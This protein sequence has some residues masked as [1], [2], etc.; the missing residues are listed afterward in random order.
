[1]RFKTA[2][3][4]IFLLLTMPIWVIPWISFLEDRKGMATM[5]FSGP[6]FM[7]V[8]CFLILLSM[9]FVCWLMCLLC[10]EGE[11]FKN[12]LTGRESMF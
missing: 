6:I 2:L 5:L 8:R 12:L 11:D 7:R 4:N 3:L 10:H 9:P 1:M